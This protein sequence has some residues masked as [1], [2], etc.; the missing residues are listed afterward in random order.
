MSTITCNY[1]FP[2]HPRDIFTRSSQLSDEARGMRCQMIGMIA[3]LS[4][5]FS[6]EE[7]DTKILVDANKNGEIIG[8]EMGPLLMGE[9]MTS[10]AAKRVPLKNMTSKNWITMKL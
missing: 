10:P 5:R 6:Q 9:E 3:K 8:F 2:I 7:I 1:K 4:S